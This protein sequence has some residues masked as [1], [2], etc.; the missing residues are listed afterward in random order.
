LAIKKNVGTPML[1]LQLCSYPFLVHNITATW[2]TSFGP[3]DRAWLYV[4]VTGRVEQLEVH[5]RFT[6]PWSGYTGFEGQHALPLG[7]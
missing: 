7:A 5:M 3:I 1:T 2:A 6:V 4:T